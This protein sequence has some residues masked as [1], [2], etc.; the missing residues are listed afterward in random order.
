MSAT[1]VGTREFREQLSVYLESDS[2]VAITRHGEVIGYYLPVR[3]RPRVS[4][5][6]ALRRAAAQL[7]QLIAA[8]GVSEDTLVDEFASM[9]K[10]GRRGI[11]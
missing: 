11:A 7:E 2:P 6:E 4:D 9:K 3:P 1:H 5:T 8:S 10:H